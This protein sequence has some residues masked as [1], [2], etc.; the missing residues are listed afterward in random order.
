MVPQNSE[1]DEFIDKY[2]VSFIAWDLLVFFARNPGA[3]DT[4]EGIARRLGRKA[5]EVQKGLK[6][7]S[8][9]SL[10]TTKK[11]DRGEVYFLSTNPEIRKV[12][13]EFLMRMDNRSFRL[14][15]LSRLLK[16]RVLEAENSNAI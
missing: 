8:A 16:K 12:L 11:T 5:D 4:P 1:I 7:L 2:V 14:N 6:H 15:L 10:L 13:D 9:N 3:F